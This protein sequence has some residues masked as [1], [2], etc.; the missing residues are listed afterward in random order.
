MHLKKK[1]KKNLLKFKMFTIIK[2]IIS[3]YRGKK[4]RFHLPYP[5]PQRKILLRVEQAPF[6]RPVCS[7]LTRIILYM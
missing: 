1:K 7:A 2:E 3:R 5:Y 6:S 4:F